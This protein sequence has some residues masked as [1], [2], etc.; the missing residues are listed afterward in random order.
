MDDYLSDPA[1]L[2]SAGVGGGGP[3]G[4]NTASVSAGQHDPL[5]QSIRQLLSSVASNHP[6]TIHRPLEEELSQLETSDE[7]FHRCVRVECLVHCY[8]NQEQEGRD[9]RYWFF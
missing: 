6:G 9:D 2:L 1:S 5:V 7:N 8:D 3:A 4:T